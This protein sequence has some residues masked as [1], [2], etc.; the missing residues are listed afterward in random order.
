VGYFFFSE[1]M[2]I[3]CTKGINES[4]MGMSCQ[5]VYLCILFPKVPR[6]RVKFCI[7]GS[8]SKVVGQI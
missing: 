1:L 2:F 5:S 7:G 8:T 4:I 3:Y 6:G